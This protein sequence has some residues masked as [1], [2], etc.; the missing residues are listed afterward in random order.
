LTTAPVTDE[1]TGEGTGEIED[2]LETE[3]TEQES[4]GQGGQDNL[5]EQPEGSKSGRNKG[6]VTVNLAV[7]SSS[8]PDKLEKQLKLLKKFGLL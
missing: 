5:D 6:G 7:D 2:D 8:D 1:P 4:Q 3:G